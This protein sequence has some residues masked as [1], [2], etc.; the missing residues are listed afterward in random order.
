MTE[1]PERRRVRRAVAT[2]RLTGQASATVE[3]RLLDL[4]PAGAR[5]EHLALL[6]PGGR[7]TLRL[8]AP[9]RSLALPARIVW[10]T[11]VGREQMSEGEQALRY[12]SGLM[13]GALSPEQEKGP[14]GLMERL[15]PE[16]C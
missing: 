16:V 11:V 4:S 7:C 1:V 2:G 12:H 13:F 6:R 8:P 15:H 14:A 9:S 10:T 5:I 3:F